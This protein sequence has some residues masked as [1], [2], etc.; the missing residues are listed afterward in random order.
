[1]ACPFDGLGNLAL[2]FNGCAGNA[3]GQNF[4]LLIDEFQQEIFVFVVNILD[5]ALFK[6]AVFSFLVSTAMGVRYLISLSPCAMG[7]SC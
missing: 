1:M 3:A 2:V 6:T 4:S 7:F 5:S